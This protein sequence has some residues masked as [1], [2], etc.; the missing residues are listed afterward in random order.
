MNTTQPLIRLLAGGGL[1]VLASLALAGNPFPGQQPDGKLIAVQEKVADLFE[2]GDYQ[3]ALLIYRHELAPGGDKFAQY[4][5]GYMFH[6]GRGVE[7]NVVEASA[8]YRLAAERGEASFVRLHEELWD[9]LTEAQRDSAAL[10]HANLA[11]ELGDRAVLHRLV[12]KDLLL[13]RTRNAN[14]MVIQTGFGQAPTEPLSAYR[15]ASHRLLQR[16]TYL[17]RDL[18]DDVAATDTDRQALAE[19]RADAEQEIA[20]FVESLK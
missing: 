20:R 8:W 18:G 17:E 6:S 3:R 15:R 19:L 16:I 5:V 12:E 10:R 1:L 4:M 2:Q 11:A 14:Q 13:L 7:P 9:S